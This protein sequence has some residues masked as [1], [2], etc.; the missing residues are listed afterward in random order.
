MCQVTIEELI[1]L[2]ILLDFLLIDIIFKMID[3]S[4]FSFFSQKSWAKNGPERPS[5]CLHQKE[6]K[7]DTLEKG[8]SMSQSPVIVTSLMNCT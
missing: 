7:I 5:P 3:I 6:K 1:K 4:Q 2:K 8:V